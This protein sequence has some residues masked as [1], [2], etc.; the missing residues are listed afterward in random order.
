MI[1][2][3]TLSPNYSKKIR[4]IKDLKVIV[5][6]YTGMQSKIESI[7]RLSSPKYKVSC[8]YLID[9]KGQILKM[10]EDNSMIALKWNTT[11]QQQI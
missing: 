6:H 2:K 10:I 7:K 3:T 5:L 8:H 1:T 9:R 4:K 11:G